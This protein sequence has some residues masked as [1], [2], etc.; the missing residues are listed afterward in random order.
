MSAEEK[1]LTLEERIGRLESLM[2][3]LF[4]SLDGTKIDA[5]MQEISRAISN[6]GARPRIQLDE[7]EEE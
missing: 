3:Q 1:E 5:T 4:G 6:F 2:I 7:P